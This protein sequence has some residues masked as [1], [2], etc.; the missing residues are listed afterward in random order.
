MPL[1][2]QMNP[3]ASTI[4]AGAP[5]EVDLTPIAEGQ[6]IKVFWRGKPIFINHRTKKEIEEAAE[7]QR[8]EPARSAAR[9][10]AGQGGP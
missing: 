3:D 8:R 9:L 4:A 1:I 5:I 7:R 2:A 10:G 6:V